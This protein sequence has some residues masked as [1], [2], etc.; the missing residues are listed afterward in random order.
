M[1]QE[2][3]MMIDVESQQSPID[4]EVLPVQTK[5]AK[6]SFTG[7][8]IA[9]MALFLVGS[10]IGSMMSILWVAY[11][12][13]FLPPPPFLSP[14]PQISKNPIQLP[15]GE[16]SAQSQSIV[17]IAGEA[18]KAV[19]RIDAYRQ[20]RAGLQGG[21][22][23]GFVVSADGYIMTNA[24]VIENAQSI[25]VTLKSG[26]VFDAMIV[27]KDTISDIALVKIEAR[28]LPVLTF[29]DSDEVLVGET[30][31]AIGN[32]FGYDY[33]VTSGVVSAI[34]RDIRPPQ[35]TQPS[36]P[37]SFSIP[38]PFGFDVPWGLPSEPQAPQTPNTPSIPMV[39]IIQ[40]DAAINPGNSG[41]PLMNLNG[42]V[43]GVNFLIDAQGQ[44]I[45]FAV[46]SNIAKKV[47]HDLIEFGTVSWA[48]LGIVISDNNPEIQAKLGLKTAVGVVVVEV[49]AGKA[50]DAGIKK[51]DVIILFEGE[52]F[53]KGEE[54][55]SKIRSR[56]VGDKVELT[57]NRGGSEIKITAELGEL[58][59]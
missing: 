44:G 52:K 41:G 8:I 29:A 49:P 22:G 40:T 23:S 31:V 21:Y 4:E 27:G 12:P 35:A 11:E 46:S 6:N 32:P 2:V 7:K 55:I 17:I 51:N 53:S 42:E 56:N 47:A 25:K 54:L 3:K 16:G 13:S 37:D 48:S 33:T 43:I 28:N 34:Q 39:G 50:R 1:F 45:G 20:S 24:H 59:R 10:L 18:S 30:V 26:E 5:K 14:Q 9:G 57:I 15:I 36:Q 38:F 58:R 19:V